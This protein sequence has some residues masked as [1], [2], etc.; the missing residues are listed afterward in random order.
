MRL[1]LTTGSWQSESH[2]RRQRQHTAHRNV[3]RRLTQM[4]VKAKYQENRSR[5]KPDDGALNVSIK[6]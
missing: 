2:Q 4:G 5:A 6:G 3:K 1:L